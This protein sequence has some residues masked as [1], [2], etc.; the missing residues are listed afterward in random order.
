STWNDP[1]EGWIDNFNGP[2]G[3]M[4]GVG[5]GLIRVVRTDPSAIPDNVP[6]DLVIKVVIIM[7]WRRGIKTEINTI[8][9]YNCTSNQIKYLTNKGSLDVGMKITEEIPLDNILWKPRTI[10]TTSS[11]VYYILVLL[12]HVIPATILD[13]MMK[14]YG[15]RS[16]VLRLYRKVY[17][18]NTFASH[19]SLNK[20]TFHNTK[21]NT[22]VD[23]LSADN[24][25]DFGFDYKDLDLH[26]YY[27]KAIKGCKFY[28]L[29]ENVD[30]LT[31]AKR[32]YK[33][34]EW[35]DKIIKTLFVV[36]MLWILYKYIAT[37]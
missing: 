11:F 23:N 4:V 24:W 17:V 29:D 6:V 28:L 8:D 7:A 19:F 5:K 31:A 15:A 37:Y 34:M 2:V 21:W 12:L 9:I 25:K 3:L 10:L 22:A 16:I 14:L 27:R 1:V 35:L 26:E 33:R 18:V 36:F 32:H 13:G 30:D 20:W